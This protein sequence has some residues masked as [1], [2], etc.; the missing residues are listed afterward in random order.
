[1]YFYLSKTLGVLT[2]PSTALL[3]GLTLGLLIALLGRRKTGWTLAGLCFAAFWAAAVLP[4]GE[5]AVRHLEERFPQPQALPADIGGIIA[6]GGAIDPYLSRAR[7]QLSVGGS[8][9]RVLFLRKLAQDYPAAQLVYTGGSGNLFDQNAKEA[10]YFQT[11]ANLIGWPA[12]RVILEGRS[13]NTFENA[14]FSKAL[15]TV[16]PDKPWILITSARH[17]PRA[18]GIF[19]SQGWPVIPY[20][21][22]YVT[23]PKGSEGQ[24][25]S[26]NL[27]QGLG[28]LDTAA[29]EVVGLIAARLLGHSD[30]FFPGPLR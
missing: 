2:Q 21:V 6:L 7:H 14:T 18:V 11:F 8:I 1:M 30:A 15:V 12:D 13:R 26:L 28:M 16:T 23:Q 19:R 5:A 4:V 20:P 22:D 9:E 25:L 3:I 10:D 17:M 24:A 29:H 27:S